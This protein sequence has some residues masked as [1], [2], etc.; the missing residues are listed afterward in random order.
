MIPIPFPE[1]ADRPIV[2]GRQQELAVGEKWTVEFTPESS[3]TTIYLAS[4]GISKVPGS[5]YEVRLD[6]ET[7]YGPDPIPPTDVDDMGI[8]FVPTYQFE[9]SMT[10]VVRNTAGSTSTYNLQ[11]IGWEA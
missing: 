4:V 5:T 2:E 3:G 11:P 10:V 8:V 1:P 6:G 7:V 9:T